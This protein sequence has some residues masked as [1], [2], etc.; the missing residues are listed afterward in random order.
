MRN[1]EG[2]PEKCSGV[3]GTGI[4]LVQEDETGLV[5]YRRET[6][7]SASPLEALQPSHRVGCVHVCTPVSMKIPNALVFCRALMIS[8]AE[9]HLTTAGGARDRAFDP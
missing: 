3:G 9:I 2:I 4:L 6:S 7:S 1:I 8:C 5:Q